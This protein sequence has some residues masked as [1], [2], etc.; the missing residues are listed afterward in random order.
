VRSLQ[1]NFQGALAATN[2]IPFSVIMP[3]Y[4]GDQTVRLA[5]ALQSL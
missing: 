3:F 1:R 5:A 2:H 4:K